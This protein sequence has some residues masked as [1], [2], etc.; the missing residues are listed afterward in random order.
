M[1][2]PYL[3]SEPDLIFFLRHKKPKNII[4]ECV[5]KTGILLIENNQVRFFLIKIF[6]FI[7]ETNQKA[8]LFSSQTSLAEAWSDRREL[9]TSKKVAKNERKK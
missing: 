5:F 2:S 9:Q 4:T 3:K 8:V 7:H 1:F 6:F